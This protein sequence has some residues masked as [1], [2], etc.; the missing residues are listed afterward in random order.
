MFAGIF[1]REY[2]FFKVG[3][4]EREYTIVR[5]KK[6]RNDLDLTLSYK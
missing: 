6:E 3:L 2:I 1:L 4:S 5:L